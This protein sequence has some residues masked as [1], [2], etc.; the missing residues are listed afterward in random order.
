MSVIKARRHE[1]KAEYVNLADE[2]FV[3]TLGF[4]TRLSNRYQRLL[5]QDAMHL[6]S[7][8]LDHAEKANNM[9]AIDEVSFKARERH[10]L[11]CRSAVMAL[12]VHMTHIWQILILNPE[13]CFTD[14]KGRMKNS[15]Q[16][17]ETL[18]KWADNLG[19][20]IDRLKHMVGKVMESDK[21]KYK[22]DN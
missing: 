16:A 7:E 9:R 22:D 13:G 2:I 10:L 1:S 12:D 17:V 19:E 4:L 15:S 5:A 20:K 18:D 21:K 6:A 3:E 8:V 11:E 14:T